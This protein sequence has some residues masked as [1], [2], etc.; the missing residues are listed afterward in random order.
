M[1]MSPSGVLT[2][3]AGNGISG[4]SGDGGP[5]TSASLRFVLDVPGVAVDAAGNLYISDCSNLVVRKVD[6]RGIITT[7][8]G[9]GQALGDGG[10]AAEAKLDLPQGLAVDAA[11]NLYIADTEQNRIRKVRPDGVI[12]TVAGTGT[13]GFSGDGGPATSARLQRPA[14]VAVDAAGRIY[15]A[16]TDNDRIRVVAADGTISSFGSS[17]S[18]TFPTGIAIDASGNVYVADTFNERVVEFTSDGT[19]STI[20]GNGF[21]G[22]SGDGGAATQASLRMPSARWLWMPMAI[23]TS[24]IT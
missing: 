23:S 12:S 18:L 5:A 8:A 9:G 1:K 21:S 16:D 22:F 7:V 15:I 11:G 13:S 4:F 24:P 14:G 6:T 10:P 2:V 17:A 3:V 19:P 20:A